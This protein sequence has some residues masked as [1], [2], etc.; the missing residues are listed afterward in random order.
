MWPVAAPMTSGSTTA[1]APRRPRASAISSRRNVPSP[2][3]IFDATGLTV[4][5]RDARLRR[6]I[7][8]RA[9]D[10]LLRSSAEDCCG[11][12]HGELA[13]R[14]RLSKVASRVA[15]DAINAL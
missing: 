14:R 2:A 11:H 1:A 15:Y 10:E 9:I 3:S 6:Q 8:C 4:L 12:G 13:P 5:L 7:D